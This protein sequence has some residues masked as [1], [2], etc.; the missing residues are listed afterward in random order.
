MTKKDTSVLI[1]DD[2]EAFRYMLSA[3]LTNS[4]FAVETAGDGVAAIN[5]VQNKLYDVVLCDV[6]MPKVDGVEVLRFIKAN[7]PAIE[8]VMLTGMSDVKIAVECMRLGSYDYITK[9]TSAD[10]LLGT[11]QRALERRQLLI[12]N[13]VLRGTID[14]LQGPF[15]MVGESEVFRKV[16][17]IAAKVAPTESTVLIQGASGT[18]KELIATYIYQQSGRST[19]PF[20]TLNCASIPDTLIESE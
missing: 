17:E 1:V 7:F 5:A 4:G 12:D 13:L 18:G 14:R 8:V 2:E 3:L 15:E 16:L 10:E 19:E 11:I 20:V 9:P 6:K